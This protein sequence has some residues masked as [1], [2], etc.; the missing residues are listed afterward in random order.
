M[1]AA[2]LAT[3]RL[4]AQEASENSRPRPP[5]L[6]LQVRDSAG[7]ITAPVVRAE[8]LLSDGAFLAAVRNGFAVRFA[9]RL[10]LWRSATIF[11]RLVRETL[12]EAVAVQDPV[13]NTYALV[14]EPGGKVEIYADA[15]HLGDALA[16]TYT[17]GMLPTPGRNERYYYI[18]SL[19]I[20][21]LTASEL[22]DV[23]RWLRGD[24]GHAITERGDLGNAL[25]R[26]A[27][28]LLIR[29]SGL[30]HRRFEARSESFRP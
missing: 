26:G 21:S 4:V 6:T 5:H 12:W 7:A 22:E 9:F 25:T 14:L 28:M 13:E 2:V 16:R 10:S 23:Q 29:L 15:S 27:R 11:D 18:A 17:V 24:L 8:N 1:L 20:E 30:P 3:G 19:E